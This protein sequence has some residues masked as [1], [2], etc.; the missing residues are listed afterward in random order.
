M[1]RWA[2]SSS[3]GFCSTWSPNISIRT[4][5]KKVVGLSMD[6]SRPTI[7]MALRR[8]CPSRSM[9]LVLSFAQ[10]S[11]R[12][13]HDSLRVWIRLSV[14]LALVYKLTISSP[15]SVTVA[16]LVS[17]EANADLR[18]ADSAVDMG[19][20]CSSSRLARAGMLTW[21]AATD[22]RLFW[23]LLPSPAWFRNS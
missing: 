20:Q 5:E 3:G 8:L 18:S 10:A 12:M 19:M 7:L 1:E 11:V 23:R 22:G 6:S 13:E 4:S 21:P 15:K 17:R 2:Q 14:K 9:F 16:N